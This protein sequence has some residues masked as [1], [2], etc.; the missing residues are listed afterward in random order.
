MRGEFPHLGFNPAPGD[1]RAV[2][3]LSTTLGHVSSQCS[4]THADVTAIGH[5]EGIW[6][7]RSADAFSASFSEVPPYLDRAVSALDAATR[8][9]Q[10]WRVRL[11]GFQARARSLEEEASVAEQTLRAAET[12][13]NCLPVA[14]SEMTAAQRDNLEA[15]GSALQL[16]CQVAGS[17]IES[18]HA[19]A[20]TLRYEYA[21]AS[22]DAARQLRDAADQAPPEPGTFDFVGDFFSG[23]LDFVTDPEVWKLVGDLFSDIAMIIGAASLFAFVFLSGPVGWL[24]ATAGLG[25]AVGAFA[26]HRIALTG[27]AEDVDRETL[28]FDAI[29][30][31]AAALG[32]GGVALARSGQATLEA[33]RTIRAAGGFANF[34][35]SIPPRAVGWLLVA[36]GRFHEI[37]GLSTGNVASGISRGQGI[38]EDGA[39]WKDVPVIGPVGELFSWRPDDSGGD[40]VEASALLRSA[41][42]SFTTGLRAVPAGAAQ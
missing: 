15:T 5:A 38:A 7:G 40:R 24:L 29:G 22:E 1:L 32:V 37:L 30:V 39:S 4:T 21:S 25:F 11:D 42:Q 23:V 8:A 16:R 35:R 20:T 36:T 28:A 27:G 19:R 2:E 17:T 18:I 31:V 9:V 14:S 12:E 33:G 3:Q 6:V 26:F 10:Q 34:F 41:G 13:L